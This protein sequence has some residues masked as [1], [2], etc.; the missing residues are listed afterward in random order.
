MTEPAVKVVFPPSLQPLRRLLKMKSV[1]LTATAAAWDSAALKG[2]P[3]LVVKCQTL[4][5]KTYL[6]TDTET[7]REKRDVRLQC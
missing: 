2:S 5:V 1:I 7:Q 6:A 4:P 3:V